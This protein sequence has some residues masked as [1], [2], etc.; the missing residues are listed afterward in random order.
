MKS[1][2]SRALLAALVLVAP[3][4]AAIPPSLT[5]RMGGAELVDVDYYAVRGGS[6]VTIA[7]NNATPGDAIWLYA[8]PLLKTGEID[9]SAAILL[10]HERRSD[11]G[12]LSG[13]FLIPKEMDETSFVLRA[14]SRS[15]DGS[16]GFSADVRVDVLLRAE[17]RLE[18]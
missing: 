4:M 5:I 2:L 14:Y 10:K 7:V 11:L 9:E 17:S 6:L 18:K 3:A 12:Q 13:D 16:I 15:L 1:T 8:A